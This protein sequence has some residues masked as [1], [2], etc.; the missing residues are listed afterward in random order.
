[1]SELLLDTSITVI[2]V[3]TIGICAFNLLKDNK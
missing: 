2:A 3:L 1:M